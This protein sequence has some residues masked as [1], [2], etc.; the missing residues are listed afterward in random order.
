MEINY[1]YNMLNLMLILHAIK[2]QLINLVIFS[3]EGF[4]LKL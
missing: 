4:K 1:I 3:L 2:N